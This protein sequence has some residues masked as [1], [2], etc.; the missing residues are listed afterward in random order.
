LARARPE[1]L[2][3]VTLHYKMRGQPAQALTQPEKWGPTR[4]MERSQVEFSRSENPSFLGPV[5]T[6]PGTWNA[7]VYRPP[8][9]PSLIFAFHSLF[10][11]PW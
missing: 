3:L 2:F 5:W 4:P 8:T 7:Q 10:S 11:S 1:M 6:R 9:H